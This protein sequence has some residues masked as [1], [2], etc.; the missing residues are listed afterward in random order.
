MTDPLLTAKLRHRMQ[1]RRVVVEYW[2]PDPMLIRAVCDYLGVTQARLAAM[3]GWDRSVLNRYIKG[4]SNM[5][6]EHADEFL[7]L[8]ARKCPEVADGRLMLIVHDD[9]QNDA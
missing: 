9:S 5:S 3:I 7:Q 8:L 4:K 2:A 6:P 1:L